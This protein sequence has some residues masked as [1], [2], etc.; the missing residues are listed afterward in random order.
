LKYK[1][2]HFTQH[3]DKHFILRVS[4]PENRRPL[5]MHELM[6]AY[7]SIEFH[8]DAADIVREWILADKE[9]LASALAS[10]RLLTSC[11]VPDYH[12]RKVKRSM[13]V[14]TPEKEDR[15]T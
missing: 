9:M 14:A 7:D 11:Y 6:S 15:A 5:D 13:E 2:N 8:C 12:Y 3:A 4:L 10:S 1:R